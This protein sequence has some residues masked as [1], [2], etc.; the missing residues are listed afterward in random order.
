LLFFLL[1]NLI[2]GI[3]KIE[4]YIKLRIKKLTD[5][6]SYKGS[7]H[8]LYLPVHGQRTRT[9]QIRNVVSVDL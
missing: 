3:A 2:V 7:R 9:I 5:V 8:S 4:R 1:D 6:F